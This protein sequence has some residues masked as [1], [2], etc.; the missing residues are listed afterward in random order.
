MQNCQSKWLAVNCV[1]IMLV[2]SYQFQSVSSLVWQREATK[3][4]T[5]FIALH[6]A[7]RVSF[8][9]S[10]WEFGIIWEFDKGDREETQKAKKDA[11]HVFWING[12]KREWLW[13]LVPSRQTTLDWKIIIYFLEWK[14]LQSFS[15]YILYIPRLLAQKR[16]WI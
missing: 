12:E 8:Y 5:S 9:E 2:S 1:M 11:W 13:E 6:I 4:I 10:L 3:S 7:F 14:P 16:N 15:V